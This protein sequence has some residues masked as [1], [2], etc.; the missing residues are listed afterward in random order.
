MAHFHDYQNVIIFCGSKSQTRSWPAQTLRGA[1]QKE[2][3]I[4]PYITD[5]SIDKQV[6]SVFVLG[7][8]E[9]TGYFP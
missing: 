5:C 2:P 4:L 9:S 6:M 3:L 1:L 7:L 8:M